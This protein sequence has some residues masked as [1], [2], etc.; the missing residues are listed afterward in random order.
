M[1]KQLHEMTIPERQEAARAASEA[2][3]AYWVARRAERPQARPLAY[4][5]DKYRRA[6]G[7]F[8]YQAME[9]DGIDVS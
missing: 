2:A 4:F 6:G 8:D 5:Y 7:G 9:D 3:R 1:T